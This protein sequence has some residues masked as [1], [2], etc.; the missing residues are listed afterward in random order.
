MADAWGG[1]WGSAWGSSW[2]SSVV[3]PVVET[4]QPGGG[5]RKP[6]YLDKQGRPVDLKT[7]RARLENT[8]VQAAKQVARDEPDTRE[9]ARQL[10]DAI[11]SGE[12][13]RIAQE[14]RSA[15]E[16]LT[17]LKAMLAELEQIVLEEAED[18]EAAMIM[19]LL[20]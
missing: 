5:Y 10:R 19:L 2:G 20:A 17:Q 18:D 12:A 7:Y 16:T 14:A 6:I 13:E 15:A 11:A 8:V 9:V 3:P 1:S 4:R